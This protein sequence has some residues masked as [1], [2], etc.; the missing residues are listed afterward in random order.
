MNKSEFRTVLEN[1]EL[2]NDSLSINYIG[3]GIALIL[4]AFKVNS[5]KCVTIS[6]KGLENAKKYCIEVKYDNVDDDFSKYYK[7]IDLE[8]EKAVS[9][10]DDPDTALFMTKR[11]LF[12]N[13]SDDASASISHLTGEDIDMFNERKYEQ[14]K[15]SESNYK[16]L[17][18]THWDGA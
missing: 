16:N 15:D 17:C 9:I 1:V 7:G 12:K 13:S 11:R 14:R 4:A 6:S 10:T 8:I 3:K 2:I 5:V 18:D